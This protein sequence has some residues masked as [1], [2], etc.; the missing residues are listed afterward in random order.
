MLATFEGFGPLKSV[1]EFMFGIDT[2]FMFML[3]IELPSGPL[4]RCG[5]I[6]LSEGGA[7]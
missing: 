5:G 1:C 3:F 2:S 6:C 7:V 4:S